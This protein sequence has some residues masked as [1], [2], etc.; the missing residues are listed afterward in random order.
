[1]D[2]PCLRDDEE[3]SHTIIVSHCTVAGI[4]LLQYITLLGLDS[5]TAIYEENHELV[6]VKMS[7]E[8][9]ITVKNTT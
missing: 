3:G 7:K 9:G 5:D 2:S 1:V 4:V 6:I 8:I